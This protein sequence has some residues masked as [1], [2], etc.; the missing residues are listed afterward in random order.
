MPKKMNNDER[1]RV[2][3]KHREEF[4]ARF[5]ERIEKNEVMDFT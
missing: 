2:E 3:E 5:R 1:K 4:K